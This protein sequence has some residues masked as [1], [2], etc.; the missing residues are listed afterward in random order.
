MK[1][2]KS[3]IFVTLIGLLIIAGCNGGITI[4]ADGTET[5]MWNIGAEPSTL[6]PMAYDAPFF[7]DLLFDG[8]VNYDS[9]TNKI[10]PG[11][12]SSWEM[13]DAQ[14]TWTF[15]IDPDIYWIGKNEDG[16]LEKKRPVNSEDV[17]AALVYFHG[18]IYNVRPAQS[19][20]ASWHEK[21][22][23]KPTVQS[24]L[25]FSIKFDDPIA[26]PDLFFGE[27]FNQVIPVP[28][29]FTHAL[30]GTWD[31]DIWFRSDAAYY[32]DTWESGKFIQLK[33]NPFYEGSTKDLP[34]TVHFTWENQEQASQKLVEGKLDL[35]E[36]EIGNGPFMMDRWQKGEFITIGNGTFLVNPDAKRIIENIASEISKSSGV[37]WSNAEYDQLIEASRAAYTYQNAEATYFYKQGEYN[38]DSMEII[39]NS[40]FSDLADALEAGKIVIIE[41]L[42]WLSDYPSMDNFVFPENYV[43]RSINRIENKD[44]T[45]NIELIDPETDKA[46]LGLIKNDGSLSIP[47]AGDAEIT[48]EAVNYLPQESV[49]YY[50]TTYVAFN[51][52]FP[53]YDQVEVRKSLAAITDREAYLQDTQGSTDGLSYSLI[54][55]QLLGEYSFLGDNYISQ[56]TQTTEVDLSVLGGIALSYCGGCEGSDWRADAVSSMWGKSLGSGIKVQPISTEE[57]QKPISGQKIGMTFSAGNTNT[58]FDFAYQWVKDGWIMVPDA[59][60]ENYMRFV[61]ATALE[62]DKGK[63]A[64]MIMEINRVLTEEFISAIPLYWTKNCE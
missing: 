33:I 16:E 32:L 58:W 3:V 40:V 44:G 35:V 9:T 37:M 62:K 64:L 56:F 55:Q 22:I 60:Y 19:W 21:M 15:H 47:G 14:T 26:D 25:I 52:G 59:E 41:N 38:V 23:G 50:G 11:L 57:Y 48:Y 45:H 36:F 43:V 18:L 63:Q 42:G 30:S 34:G 13:D 28:V 20:R 17:Q 49:C 2:G 27:L 39:N 51:L 5:I 46:I 6:D 29:E 4:N 61:E 12:L 10:S 24:E 31:T 8:L 1:S 53:P 54:P 7:A